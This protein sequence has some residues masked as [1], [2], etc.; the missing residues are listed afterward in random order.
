[1]EHAPRPPQP[2]TS[3]ETE[4]FSLEKSVA[5][6]KGVIAAHNLPLESFIDLYGPATIAADV[7]TIQRMEKIFADKNTEENK[8]ARFNQLA[9]CFEGFFID[10]V[11]RG[12]LGEQTKSLKTSRYDDIING[13]DSV[14]E[15][16][17]PSQTTQHLGLALDATYSS[18]ALEGKF[19]KIIGKLANNEM[20]SVKY[21]QSENTGFRGEYKMP[22]FVAGISPENLASL[23]SVWT[24]GNEQPR[25]RAPRYL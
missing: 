22:L 3:R 18:Q 6:A 16:T 21:F 12:M 20:T 5:K 14:T 2:T 4:N 25:G 8:D 1:M 19:Y 13:V 23:L 17:R 11:D 15:I 9:T 10:Q 7:N 24:S